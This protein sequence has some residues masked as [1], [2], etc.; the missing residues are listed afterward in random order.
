MD[1]LYVVNF[2]H[3]YECFEVMIHLLLSL[4][5]PSLLPSHFLQIPKLIIPHIPRSKMRSATEVTQR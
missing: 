1:I 3:L 2:I 5:S 4:L